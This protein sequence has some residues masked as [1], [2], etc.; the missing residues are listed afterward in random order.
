MIP[1][2]AKLAAILMHCSH[3]A[4]GLTGTTVSRLAADATEITTLSAAEQPAEDRGDACG[5]DRG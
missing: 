4:Q 2:T 3:A 1:L 5:L